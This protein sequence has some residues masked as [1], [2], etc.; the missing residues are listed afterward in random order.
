MMLTKTELMDLMVEEKQITLTLEN[1]LG[2]RDAAKASAEQSYIATLTT[3][4]D[5]YTNQVQKAQG[6][7]AE[8]RAILKRDGEW[9]DPTKIP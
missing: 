9:V 8:I 5:T 3:I 7:L 2:A 1:A 4:A 6:R